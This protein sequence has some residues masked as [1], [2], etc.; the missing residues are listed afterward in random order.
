MISLE[1]C[2]YWLVTTLVTQTVGNIAVYGSAMKEPLT[3][4]MGYTV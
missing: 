1:A 2:I 4:V 3:V